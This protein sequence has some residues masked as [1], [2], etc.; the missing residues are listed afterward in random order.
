MGC[1]LFDTN[2]FGIDR[3]EGRPRYHYRQTL[4]RTPQLIAPM[5]NSFI[6]SIK[7]TLCILFYTLLCNCGILLV[8]MTFFIPGILAFHKGRAISSPDSS[9]ESIKIDSWYLLFWYMKKSKTN[10]CVYTQARLPK[11][12]LQ[13]KQCHWHGSHSPRCLHMDWR[14]CLK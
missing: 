7:R 3:S 1:M 11:M 14:S 5:V 9:R 8:D 4:I 13:N 2:F 10:L 6:L 12:C